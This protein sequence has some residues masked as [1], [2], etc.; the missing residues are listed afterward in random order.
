MAIRQISRIT[1]RKGLSEN[2]PQLAGAELGWV[3]DDRK[4]YIGNGT[5]TEGAPEIGN[6]EIL[7]EFSDI[8][9]AIGT[10]T[11]QGTEGGYTVQTGP[12]ST[13][14]SSRTVQ[15][16]L[17][18][19][20]SVKDF[21][22]KGDGNTDDTEAINRALYQLF[23]VQAS[24]PGARRSLFFPA[25]EYLVSDSVL[26]PPYAKI[27]G[28]GANSTIIRL[29]VSLDGSS[30]ADYVARTC[31]NSQ[32]IGVNIGSS[33]D[34][35]TPQNIEISSITFQTTG[36]TDIFL[37]DRAEQCYFDSVNFLGPLTTNIQFSN[38]PL[39]DIA[40]V[41][42]DSTTVV[43]CTQINF[44]K[45]KFKGLTYGVY[46]D[47][48]IQGITFSNSV[49]DSLYRGIDIGETPVDSGPFGVRVIHNLFDNIYNSGI[50]FGLINYNVTAYNIFKNVANELLGAGSPIAPV[51]EF[52]DSDNAS[53]GDM[54]ERNDVDAV[55]FPRVELSGEQSI[56]TTNGKEIQLGTYHRQSGPTTTIVDN[57]ALTTLFTI[58][59]TQTKAFRMDYTFQRDTTIRHG[60]LNVVAM[61]TGDSTITL[62]YNEDYTE[63]GTSGLTF[64]ATE[65]GDST[66][67]S[68]SVQYQTT[69]TGEAGIL[70][71]SLMFIA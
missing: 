70:Q 27:W 59:T 33:V 51:I 22:A 3:V 49:F 8:L 62:N 26:I 69:N 38:L 11:Y 6:T 68:I 57:S 34:P 5:L 44:D 36:A 14:P 9:G 21:G 40:G 64:S 30:I 32:N 13:D 46:T 31:D 37:V 41:R 24:Y 52:Q 23:C 19:F 45:C 47:Q 56:A 29:I 4:L 54:F 48:V 28:E 39:I 58:S 18:D 20:A 10:Y 55:V 2:L 42:F 17:D 50:I 65:T 53:I 15:L 7:T 61:D 1:H 60:T 66:L 63:N 67:S 43:P 12:T 16:K 35:I 71:Y 25:G